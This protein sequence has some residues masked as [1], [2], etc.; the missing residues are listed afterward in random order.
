MH[1][2]I[3]FQFQIV[4]GKLFQFRSEFLALF[5]MILGV[6]LLGSIEFLFQIE[7]TSVVSKFSCYSSFNLWFNLLAGLK[8]KINLHHKG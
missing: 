2:S 8:V 3:L 4:L 5:E 7:F 1:L 6:L